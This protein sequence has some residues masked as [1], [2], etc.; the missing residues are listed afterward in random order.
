MKKTLI[1]TALGMA[2]GLTA[3]TGLAEETGAGCGLGKMIMEGKSGKG[4]NIT[5][6]IINV[7]LIP[8]T[9][10]MSTAATMGE[11]ILGCDPTKTVMKE[12]QKKA[13]VAAN[14]DNLSRDMAQGSGAHLE[15]LAT[16][17][18]IAEED[19]TSF[20]SMAQEEFASLDFS[21]DDSAAAVVAGLN[22]A[23]LEY[24]E[25]AKYTR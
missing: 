15:V 2:M 18:G 9:L 5:A 8:N 6:A 22:T 10:F 23:M 13:F 11:E 16:I 4:A 24:P 17:M 21:A 12:E 25:L 1:V 14:M 7:V 3:Q 20:F 19:R